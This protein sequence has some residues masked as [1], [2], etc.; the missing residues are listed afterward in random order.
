VVF[1]VLVVATEA[2][3]TAAVDDDDAEFLIGIEVD[4]GV[5]VVVIFV[6]AANVTMIDG[7]NPATYP[8][9]YADSRCFVVV[10]VVVAVAVAADSNHDDDDDDDDDID[11]S[12]CPWLEIEIV[13]KMMIWVGALRQSRPQ[14]S[15]H[16]PS[17]PPIHSPIPLLP[18]ALDGAAALNDDDDDTVKAAAVPFPSSDR[19]VLLLFYSLACC[20]RPNLLWIRHHFLFLI[21]RVHN[22]DGHCTLFFL[23]FSVIS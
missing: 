3:A 7:D 11:S 22:R 18:L 6:A 17:S 16:D 10:V 19:L 20:L 12:S 15:Q 23:V 4:R 14:T 21:M 8:N 13:G 9:T 2:T 1:V 5:G